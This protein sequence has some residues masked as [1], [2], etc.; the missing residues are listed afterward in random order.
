LFACLGWLI[1]LAPAFQA[2]AAAPEK[3]KRSLLLRVVDEETG[4]PLAGVALDTRADQV[5]AK[6]RTDAQ[7]ECVLDIPETA[8]RYFTVWAK[9]DGFVPVY[10]EWHGEAENRA[11]I[12]NEHTLALDKATAIGGLIQDEQGKPV[13][14]ATVFVLVPSNE[15]REPGKPRVSVW[16]YEAKTDAEGRWHCDVVPAKLDDVWLRL[17]H[18][19]F[20]SD[21]M[22]GTTP[23][24]SLEKLRDRTGVM[25]LKKGIAVAGRV[26]SSDGK[27]IAGARVAQGADRWGSHYP[28]TKTNE[29]GEFHFANCRAGEMILTV[30]AKGYSPD[31]RRILVA[32]EQ[33][34]VDFTLEPSHRIS[35]R[36]VDPQGNP[37]YGAFVAADTWRGYR[38][39]AFRVNTDKDGK[40]AW[41]DGPGDEVL[42]DLGKEGYMSL[43]RK[44]LK[45]ST[46]EQIITL[47]KPLKVTGAVTDADTGR[48]I[49]ALTVLPG[50]DWGNGQSPYWE[51]Q[52]ARKQSGGQFAVEFAEPRAGHLIRIEA[53]GYR[54][55]SSRAFK[56]SE[57]D[58]RFDFALKKG[59]GLSGVVLGLDGQ[60]L[61][62]ASVCLV[63]AGSS[64]QFANGR[65][66]DRRDTAVV[67][68]GRDGRFQFP[69]QEGKFTLVVLHASGFALRA[70]SQLA[71]SQDVKLEGWGRVE[72]S[73]RVGARPGAGEAVHLNVQQ[74]GRG[75]E[76]RPYFDY[77]TTADAQGHYVIERVP[78]GKVYV[79]R[80]IKLSERSTGYSHTTPVEVKAG[81]SARADIGG[82]GRPVVGRVVAPGGAK[83]D[84]AVGF[85]GMRLAQ[86]KLDIPKDLSPEQRARWYEEW[87]QTPEGK[88][89][90]ERS[91]RNYCVKIEG[92]GSFRVD[93]VPAGDYDLNIVVNEPLPG[94]QCAIGGDLLGSV[95][96]K[97]N[98]PEMRGGR[99]DE[100]LDLGTLELAMARRVKVGDAAPGFQVATLEGESLKL[101][102]FRGK[103]VLLDFWAT[104]CGPCVA[105]TPHLKEAYEAFRNDDRFAMIGLDLDPEKD[106]PRQYVAKNSLRWH[107]AF[108][109]DFSEAKLP[110]EYGV[111]GIP[112]VWLIGPDGKVIATDLRGAAIKETIA[113]ALDEPK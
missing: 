113:R 29:Q 59:E 40:F 80:E 93:D 77:R 7:G 30:Q 65:P 101:E 109:G 20:A 58:V 25:V 79:A 106:A 89:Y 112:S 38:S 18:P 49:D 74:E 6:A 98:V 32:P 60:P 31:L 44:A 54:P 27:P 76:P 34:S 84:W 42:F 95:T 48:P 23:R 104:W 41:D 72:G 82:T 61:A 87:S 110:G 81:Q 107:Q 26:R 43:R 83:V 19:D 45:A 63:T 73:V 100:P 28:D 39:I 103:F 86:P 14:G 55:V 57:G 75:D 102:D 5:R 50:I 1:A 91:Q 71:A 33:A 99:S 85:H 67:E 9:K 15:A 11:V 105:E 46:D 13:A 92:D 47:I 94:N 78:P 66:P 37:V 35:G 4:R 88:A 51:R 70:E 108:L 16:D 10:V 21:T 96:H 68:T 90:Q 2:S 62:D 8:P 12:P 53:E 17:S 36:V 56:D 64:T 24:P 97:V 111:R 52:S 3:E 69:A 22:Y